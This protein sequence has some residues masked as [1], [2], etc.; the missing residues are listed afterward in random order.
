MVKEI[1]LPSALKLTSFD[2]LRAK[3]YEYMKSNQGRVPDAIRIN[4]R[5]YTEY[6]E[7][8]LSSIHGEFPAT[9]T[10]QG[11]PMIIKQSWQDQPSIR[12]ATEM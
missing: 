3:L 7:L 12:Y 5:Q 10:F 2:K 8:F 4:R 1:I 6:R 11:I 9:P